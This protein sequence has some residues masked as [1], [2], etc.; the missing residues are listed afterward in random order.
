ME[1]GELLDQQLQ[2]YRQRAG[3][4]DEWFLRTGRYDRGPAHR[5]AWF[6]EVALVEAALR[7][8]LP[9]AG[10]VLELACGTGLWT[11]HLASGDRRV[12]AV[13]ASPE[14]LAINRQR[15]QS[16]AVEYVAAD[17]F[18]WTPPPGQFDAVVFT[19]CL[20][21]VPHTRFDA[22]WQLVGRAL[23]P[24][25]T[26]FFVDSLFEQSARARDQAPVDTSGVI[27]RRL[28]DGRAFR[29]VKVYYEPAVLE[30]ALL[31]R[32][33]TGWVRSTGRF[34]LYG[35]VTLR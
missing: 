33:W 17:L 9:P 13:D 20:S 5:D 26:A 8:T 23:T 31:E 11:R 2:Y 21:H 35:S 22:F 4:Y 32:G 10:R 1:D 18:T 15:L 25:G 14:V 29:I 3:E 19:F 12:V 16:A 27:E 7:T 28:N 34:F 30:R 6:R 24:G